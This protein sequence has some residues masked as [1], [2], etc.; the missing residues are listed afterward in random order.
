MGAES[1]NLIGG[2]YGR[3]ERMQTNSSKENEFLKAN[4][5][6]LF[7][8]YALLALVGTIFS[9]IA[10]MLDGVF[11]G[12]GVGEMALA[13]IAVVVSLM[14]IC[15]ATFQGLG[16]GASTLAGI[17]IGEGNDEEAKAVYGSTLVFSTILTI[18]FSAVT[19]LFVNPLLTFLGATETVLPYARDYAMIFLPCV[20]LCVLGQIG[21]FFC[22]VGGNPRPAA[23][24]FT[25][26][27]VLAIVV[28]YI[29]V[30]H[31]GWGTGASAVDYVVGIAG[32]LPL[33]VYL[34]KK[35]NIFVLSKRHLKISLKYTWESVK[36]GFPMF[37]LN[38]C[39]MITTVVLNRQ[40]IA[41]GGSDLHLA[42]F[43]IFNAYIVFILNGITAAFAT[44]LQPIASVNLGDQKIRPD[45]GA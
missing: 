4:M 29:L 42:A 38:F 34:Q 27:G 7:W 16:V 8:K 13:G 2:D 17:K 6:K 30:F 20:P 26:A 44:G 45:P 14:Y 19:L 25:A 41:Y 9:N 18:A 39:P 24:V 28:E 5:P 37:L 23:I 40:L 36:I 22:R 21:Y 1:A 32:T 15:Q 12:N 33:L 10:V 43:G 35:K 31:C 11:M 3:T